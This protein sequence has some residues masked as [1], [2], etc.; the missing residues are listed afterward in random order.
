MSHKAT[1]VG[2]T[3]VVLAVAFGGLLYSSIGETAEYYKHVDEV[4]ASPEQWHGKNL[5]MHG[6]AHKIGQKPGTLEYRFNVESKGQTITAFYTGVVPDTFQEDSEVV[7]HGA[8][9][10]DGVFQATEIIAKCPS[11]YEAK[12]GAAAARSGAPELVN[13][14][15][16]SG[17]N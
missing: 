16:A 17:T 5:Q 15:T 6:F 12:G 13:P 4:L 14:A 3:S 8:L 9:G 1:K 10:T 7:L 11:K 2:I